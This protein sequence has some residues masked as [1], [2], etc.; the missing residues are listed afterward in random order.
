MYNKN[1]KL[2]DIL[3][4]IK[5]W[6]NKAEPT[7]FLTICPFCDLEFK[8]IAGFIKHLK[9]KGHI[10]NVKVCMIKLEDEKIAAKN[11]KVNN[12]YRAIKVFF[13]FK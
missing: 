7:E 6:N 5:K 3:K 8:Y 2:I 10:E 9:S 1:T 11:Q 13:A 12:F 4:M